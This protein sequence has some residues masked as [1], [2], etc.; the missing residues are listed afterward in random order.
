M[1]NHLIQQVPHTADCRYGYEVYLPEGYQQDQQ[2]PIVFFLHGAGERGDQLDLLHVHGP[3]KRVLQGEHFDFI[4]VAPQC[5]AGSYWTYEVQTLTG[6]VDEICRKYHADPD[7]VYLTGLSMGGY[8]TWAMA[9]AHPENYAAIAPVCGEGMPWASETL[10]HL[11]TWAFHGSDD[12]CVPVSGSINMVNA[13]LRAGGD[14]KLTVYA[15]V[16]HDS[17]TETYENPAFYT[18]M[19]AQHRSR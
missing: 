6:F 9:I 15:G 16:G 7:R 19:L 10:K 17:W 8:G 11:P 13:I 4:C 12:T 1:N 2:Y 5:P 3:L 18:W 14:A